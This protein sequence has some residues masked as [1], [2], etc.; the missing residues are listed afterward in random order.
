M[1]IDVFDD[2]ETAAQRRKR[3]KAEAAARNGTGNGRNNVTDASFADGFGDDFGDTDTE[4]DDEVSEDDLGREDDSGFEEWTDNSGQTS[5]DQT[6]Q[7]NAEIENERLR[8]EREDQQERDRV[9]QEQE[10]QEEAVR[11]GTPYIPQDR[12]DGQGAEEDDSLSEK[13]EIVKR[14]RLYNEMDQSSRGS[15]GGDTGYTYADYQRDQEKLTQ[16]SE[17]EVDPLAR[18]R[19]Q[20]EEVQQ[21][22]ADWRGGNPKMSG[23]QDHEYHNRMA[24]ALRGSILAEETMSPVRIG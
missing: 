3:L 9:A 4:Y 24:R 15:T 6:A 18:Y 23:E 10:D 8:K 19:G 1:A 20:P 21:Q 11:M 12:Q 5:E 2:T 16:L 13:D 7:R 17:E 14:I 22:V